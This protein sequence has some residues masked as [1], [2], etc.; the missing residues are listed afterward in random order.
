VTI[1]EGQF[2]RGRGKDRLKIDGPESHKDQ[3]DG[4]QKPVIADPVDDESLL[5]RVRGGF[6]LVPEPDQ[7]VRTQA[8]PFPAHKHQEKIVR[9]NQDEHEEDEKVEVGKVPGEIPVLVHVAV[10]VYVDDERDP[11]DDHHHDDGERVDQETDVRLKLTG[12][13]PLI[14]DLFNGTTGR[15]HLEQVQEDQDRDQ[16]GKPDGRAGDEAHRPFAHAPSEK[17]V[18]GKPD[19]RK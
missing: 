18:Q 17:K 4:Q 6:F 7:E 14:Q 10:G 9:G 19:G 8:H 3:E 13:D 2:P 5:P 16:E 1:V 12:K 11:G 15:R